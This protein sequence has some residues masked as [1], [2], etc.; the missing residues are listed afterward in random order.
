MSNLNDKRIRA[1]I[2]IAGMSATSGALTSA[3]TPL[4]EI[5]KQVTVGVADIAMCL[6]IWRIYFKKELSDKSLFAILSGAGLM[7]L[8]AGG[9][10]WVI[11]KGVSGL[12]N[13]FG[14]LL[15]PIGWGL[16]GIVSVSSTATLGIAWMAYCDKRY[17]RLYPSQEKSSWEDMKRLAAATKDLLQSLKSTVHNPLGTKAAGL[18]KASITATAKPTPNV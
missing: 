11:T 10:G 6:L 13:E 18:S 17:R 3:P 14:N 2:T 4:A 5:P 7:A 9:V 12:L 15:G 1:V 16:S 8:A